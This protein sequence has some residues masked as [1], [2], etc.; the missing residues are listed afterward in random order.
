MIISTDIEKTCDKFH[1]L[2]TIKTLRNLGIE[3][4][5]LNKEYLLSM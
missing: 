5:S 4:N 2:F 1:H 3:W